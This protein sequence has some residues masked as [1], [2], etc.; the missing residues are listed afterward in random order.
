MH[1][2]FSCSDCY[3]HV[4]MYLTINR[5]FQHSGTLC[6]FDSGQLFCVG[7]GGSKVQAGAQGVNLPA[8]FEVRSF[9]RS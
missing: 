3:H 5:H 8:K 2:S 9:S 7:I 4:R 1:L 6:L